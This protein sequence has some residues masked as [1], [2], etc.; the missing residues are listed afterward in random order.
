MAGEHYLSATDRVSD[1]TAAGELTDVARRQLYESIVNRLSHELGGPLA[2]L[3]GYI[4]LW[5]DGTLDPRPWCTPSDIEFAAQT[6]EI[7][8]EE[9]RSIVASGDRGAPSDPGLELNAWVTSLGVRL[10]YSL[11]NL[12]GWFRQRDR[13]LA[14][15]M[16]FASAHAAL[17]CERSL[18]LFAALVRQLKA[19][20]SV[21]GESIPDLE[22]M[23]LADWMRRSLHEVAPAI[24]CFG[25]KIIVDFPV[26]PTVV[27]ASPEWLTLALVNIL[28]NAQK[29]SAAQ[30]RIHI[31]VFKTATL[32]GFTVEDEGPGLPRGFTLRMFGRVDEGH[33]F[34]SP[35]M[36]L[37]LY[38]TGQVAKLLGGDLTFRSIER[39]GTSVG[40]RLPRVLE[41]GI[42]E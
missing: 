29:F 33:G 21:Y 41:V 28:D 35:G 39:V 19:A 40:I 25:H 34:A 8:I 17:V 26:G 3:R 12:R 20:Q 15:E 24:T 2:V 13:Q 22:R 14:L 36:G 10:G 16:S 27:M 42:A 11:T 23:D 18:I 1:V 31:T 38:I 7:L 37:G 9:V 30:T 32:A 5:L 6:V 4:S